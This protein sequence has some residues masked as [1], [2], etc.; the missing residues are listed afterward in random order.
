MNEVLILKMNLYSSLA[1]FTSGVVFFWGAFIFSKDI[2]NQVIQLFLVYTTVTA[3]IAFFEYLILTSHTLDEAVD[4]LHFELLYWPILYVVQIHFLYRY[5]GFYF[6]PQKPLFILLYTITI[7]MVAWLSLLHFFASVTYTGNEWIRIPEN[8]TSI[9]ELVFAVYMSTMTIAVSVIAILFRRNASEKKEKLKADFVL[10]GIL[11]PTWIPFLKN[12]LL[13]GA[14][15]ISIIFPDFPFIFIG[16]SCLLIAI[17]YFR[18]FDLTPKNVADKILETMN[19]ALIMTDLNKNIVWANRRFHELFELNPNKF[20]FNIP[21]SLS[22][23][24]IKELGI[25]GEQHGKEEFKNRLFTITTFK[26]NKLY[27]GVSSSFL[28][29]NANDV[30]GTVTIMNDITELI[31]TQEKLKDQQKE[32][33]KIAHQAGMSEVTTSV[34]HNIGNILNSVNISSEFINMLLSNS[35]LP[36]LIKA[37]EMM[38]VHKDE[39]ANFITNDPKGKLLPEYYSKLGMELTSEH[40]KLKLEG[41]NLYQKIK[42]IKDA[43]DIQQ[44]YSLVR[45]LNEP[46]VVKNLIDEAIT[47]LDESFK[48]NDIILQRE[49]DSDKDVIVI[50][51]ASKLINVVLNVVKNAAE[52]VKLNHKTERLINIKI[53]GNDPEYVQIIIE[54]NGIGISDEVMP[55]IFKYGFTTKNTGH[56]FG[57][58]FCANVMGEMNGSIS[59]SSNGLEKGARFLI[60][61]PKEPV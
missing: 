51:P 5:A 47:I 26:N 33:M 41:K 13:P 28:K 14:F 56:G 9:R 61:I 40:E 10:A 60:S 18:M 48:K 20:D 24:N 12:G 46:I 43:I 52:S 38:L 8:I 50:A 25:F 4:W 15:N 49:Y 57:L 29:D 55:D 23:L 59:A 6:K 58:H 45:N 2:K 1:L 34:M 36:G 21:D 35:K 27:L 44:D 54:D 42:L 3:G 31:T 22:K 53:L 16:W 32:M 11:I 17:L 39:L 37:N 19:E 7:L 30:V